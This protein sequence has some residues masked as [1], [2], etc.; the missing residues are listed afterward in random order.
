[1]EF[2]ENVKKTATKDRHIKLFPRN[3]MI[4]SF[5]SCYFLGVAQ[6]GT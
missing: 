6:S 2:K 4:L 1:M 3:K 5:Y